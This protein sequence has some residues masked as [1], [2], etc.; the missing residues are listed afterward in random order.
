MEGRNT[1]MH[2]ST[3]RTLSLL[4]CLLMLLSLFPAAAFAEEG[5]GVIEPAAPIEEPEP[6]S[7]PEPAEEAEEAPEEADDAGVI[8]A[9]AEPAPADEPS[10][11]AENYAWDLTAGVL[12]ISGDGEMPNYGS[13]SSSR[14]PWYNDRGT[15]T[16]VV[17]QSGITRIGNWSFD[18]CPNLTTVVIPE[19]VVDAGTSSFRACTALIALP[20]LPSTM[21]VI[22]AY[23]FY[24]CSAMA[25]AS[26]PDSVTT[27][28][29]HAFANCTSLS[30][31]K[32]S[33]GLLNLYCTAFEGCTSLTSI[34]IPASLENC[35]YSY[36]D[37]KYGPFHNSGLTNVSFETDS[38]L[39]AGRLF[40]DCASL[41]EITLPNTITNI[42]EYAFYQC[43]FLSAVTLSSKLTNI[44]SNAFR[45]CTSL[46]RVVIPDTTLQIW[47]YA[48]A[49][50]SELVHVD[51]PLGLEV[52]GDHAFLNDSKLSEIDLTPNLKTL[53]CTAFEGCSS[54]TSITIPASL[55][56]CPYSYYDYK[57]GPF[58]KTGLTNVSF[59]N[60]TL[61]VT[62]RL[63]SDCST[64][65][66]I[67]LPNTITLIDERAFMNCSNLEAVTFSTKLTQING[68][69]FQNCTSL[70]SLIIPDTV[71]QIWS[72][73]FAG[74]EKL[75]HV[76]LPLGLELLA[77][78]AFSNDALLSE[79]E[80]T[81]ALEKLYCTA[82]E[83]CTSLTAIEIPASLVECPYS[84]YDYKYGPF[85]N[86]GLTEVTFERGTAK[87]VDR[88]FQDCSSLTEI[89]IPNSIT[90]IGERAFLN[91]D[92]LATVSFSNKLTAINGWAFQNCTALTDPVL[93]DSLTT[94]WGYV[95][96][97]CTTLEKILIP[98]SVTM[99]GDH[100]FY[101]CTNINEVTLSKN[102]Q[103]LYCT[104]FENCGL[105][106]TIEIPASLSEIP[107]S[108][109]DYKNGPFY[110]SGITSFTFEEGTKAILPRMFQGCPF[111]ELNLSQ[112]I[113]SIQ[114]YAF[115][116]CD[117]LLSVTLGG[118][119]SSIGN[120]A[121]QDCDALTT[122]DLQEGVTSL[123]DNV[124]EGCDTLE[125]VN[126]ADTITSIGYF[127]FRNN[128]LLTDV[129]LSRGLS[130]IGA[131]AFSNC[132]LLETIWIPASLTTIKTD[133][134]TSQN[135]PF[136]GSGLI[137]FEMEKGST[138]LCARLFEG[139]EYLKEI[140][141]PASV[142]TVGSLAFSGC[143]RLAKVKFGGN[144]P[145]IAGDTFNGLTLNA[146]YPAGNSTWSEGNMLDY[147]GTLTWF[148]YIRIDDPVISGEL[149]GSYP[150][151]TWDA[152]DGASEYEVYR[153]NFPHRSYYKYG[154][155]T[156]TSFLNDKRIEEGR[157]Y[158][159]KVLAL[160]EDGNTSE[161]SNIVS[162]TIPSTTIAAPEIV[163]QP[164]DVTVPE[165]STATFT[166][167]A[168][169]E[170][171]DYQ[172][173]YRI[174]GS[175]EWK[176]V[177]AASGKTANYSLT[178]AARHDGYQYRCEV[179]N[180]GGSVFTEIATL[181]VG[182]APTITTQPQNV[183]VDL[184]QKATFSV[185]ASGEGL[186]YQWYYRT[187]SSG[188]WKAVSATS[189][190]TAN[191]SFTPAERH[192]G[193]QYRCKVTNEF[194]SKYSKTVTLT[195][196]VPSVP[197]PVIT[198][199]P[200]SL[201]VQ[202][203]T[204]VSF[205]VAAEGQDLSF[206]WYYRTS[207]SGAWTAPSAASAK[208]AT[209]TLT[210]KARHNGY[211]YYC[212][213]SNSAGSASSEIATLTVNTATVTA[214]TITT[215]PTDQNVKLGE[216][217]KFSVV[218]AGDDLSYQW[219]Y[220]TSSSGTWKAVS[221]TSGKT[222]NY[223]FTPAERHNGY[224]YRCLVSNSAGSV[225]T[226]TVTLTIIT[227][228]VPVITSQPANQNV[229][230]GD[231]ATFS[232]VAEGEDLSYQWYYR[233]SSSG[234]WKAVSAA[235]G[236]TDTYS[237]TPAER[238]NGYQYRCVVSNEAG[239]VT[240]RTVTLTVISMTAPVIVTQ[241]TNQE[242]NLGD[243]ATFF[244]EADGDDLSYQWYYRTDSAASWKAV[245]AASG[246]TD[247]YS[248][249]PAERHNGYQYRCVVSNELGS[250][251]SRT[252]TLT[253]IIPDGPVIIAQPQSITV[254]AGEEAFFSI[255]ADGEG[256]TYKWYY[257]TS[258]TG[259]WVA[260]TGASATTD[261]YSFI[262]AASQNGYQFKCEVS[263]GS[264]TTTS[265]IVTLTV[266]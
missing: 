108:Y 59:E 66:Q 237:F 248:F 242:V 93:P 90:V 249:I 36:Y 194:G 33:K 79:I 173:Y 129:G 84:Y 115:G 221:A 190:K 250:V 19:G 80:L 105:L 261:E 120:Y 69:A 191:Y 127:A 45:E 121:F 147:G 97:G 187:S 264:G 85:H 102:L 47:G 8:D 238:H 128:P 15:I 211:Q 167:K 178:V 113:T 37:Y 111:E 60:G 258:S 54:L 12:T 20:A 1:N 230:L 205:A 112:G 32:L 17:I 150:L 206:Q 215:Q 22:G 25:S 53:Y 166:V 125:S 162:V 91:C 177:T 135:G 133:Y 6:V 164:T 63:F 161:Y 155:V 138:V 52:L 185:T 218:A 68:Y 71:R 87:I 170:S 151:I 3:K 27:I 134:Y 67:R 176:A 70:T 61:K 5:E 117:A 75:V 219:Y 256:L 55:E 44:S 233:T 202:E 198:S 83:G 110:N 156:D 137:S 197:A 200:Q 89:T 82:F 188:T 38:L 98:D 78:H 100:A 234:S 265:N 159:F 251:T 2:H 40:A 212:V 158:Y 160:D 13:S 228:T 142:E 9:V 24:G 130:T 42:G 260:A 172:W 65:K 92:H 209:Y 77:D 122:I 18:G 225:T 243:R 184:G 148:S 180:A 43:S 241:P 203:G 146:Y 11:T 46:T 174:P 76:D 235:S 64:L 245:S 116:N 88:L 101:N 107:Y 26:I 106:T 81:P 50:C 57:Y 231:A 119:V 131:A 41:T 39:V 30:S 124:F 157:T 132:P 136:H 192:N 213:V 216:K 257:R 179:S 239:S 141:I 58:Y 208:T 252:V 181:H 255:M 153:S 149:S 222:A 201:T 207:A 189:G 23:A 114:E 195:V 214:P 104:A 168:T 204:V 35:P 96:S 263:N 126:M 244:L 224:Q 210:A 186:S 74:C 165:G 118:D 51:L 56:D 152:V 95:F 183:T 123:G 182:A 240:S 199:Q 227:I 154:T 73:A 72:Y 103:K 236:K 48:F 229:T 143:S 139:T 14:P 246:K 49:G 140:T 223:S 94:I 220:R 175:T 144:A 62:T 254:S 99:I 226:R 7:E 28:Y 10:A 31:V 16:K 145:T 29:D 21:T 193:Y 232:V 262:A 253:V 247:T 109:Y 266:T 169:G 34:E 163:T 259:A 86:T 4:L 217:A 196:N 171:L